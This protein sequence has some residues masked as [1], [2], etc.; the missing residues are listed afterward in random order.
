MGTDIIYKDESYAI[1]GACFEVYKQMGSGFLEAVY[2]ECLAKE[3]AARNIPFTEQER[4]R[5]NYKG[6][7]LKQYYDADFLCY[8]KII[9]EIKAHKTLADGHRSQ[10]I[11]YLK[12]TDIKLGLLVN[13]SHHPILEHERFLNQ[14]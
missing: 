5:L 3:F 7:P 10:I 9:V 8:G 6:A 1:M 13:F 2:Q 11:H 14:A 12:S 4:L